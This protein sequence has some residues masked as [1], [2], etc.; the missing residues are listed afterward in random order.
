MLFLYSYDVYFIV[1]SCEAVEAFGDNEHDP[2]WTISIKRKF[3]RKTSVL[4]VVLWSLCIFVVLT[5]IDFDSIW[6]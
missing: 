5:G 6:L 2:M 3:T 4:V 1:S